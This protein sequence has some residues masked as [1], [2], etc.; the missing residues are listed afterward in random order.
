M[1]HE[2]PIHLLASPRSVGRLSAVL[3]AT[4]LI[5]GPAWAA[6][7][8]ESG[9]RLAETWCSTCHVVTPGGSG[10]DAAPPFPTIAE[11]RHQDPSWLR[12]WLTSPHPP[13]PNLHLTRGEIDDIVAYL[14]SLAH[15]AR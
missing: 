8:S 13:M 15:T 1:P 10:T 14:T 3:V 9:Q 5:T 12:A 7:N 11:H 6:G 2:A 4:A